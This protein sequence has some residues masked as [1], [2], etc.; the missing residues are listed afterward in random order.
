[1]HDSSGDSW[2]EPFAERTTTGKSTQAPPVPILPASA[3]PSAPDSAPLPCDALPRFASGYSCAEAVA[4]VFA[5]RFNLPEDALRRASL[6]FSG[7]LGGC[8]EACGAVCSAVMAIGMLHA[9]DDPLDRPAKHPVYALVRRFLAA[10]EA[11]H[12]SILCA[13]LIERTINSPA[14]AQEAHA[15]GLFARVCPPLVASAEEIAMRIVEG[16][17]ADGAKE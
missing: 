4:S 9:P 6:G 11:R 8:G 14:K 16:T 2:H 17:T 10:F 1:M 7:G 15:E 5:A 3:T 13:E 12:G